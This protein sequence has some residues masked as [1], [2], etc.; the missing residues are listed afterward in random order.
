MTADVPLRV[1]IATH[2][3][4][5]SAAHGRRQRWPL[6]KLYNCRTRFASHLVVCSDPASTTPSSGSKQMCACAGNLEEAQAMRARFGIS[7][8][9]PTSASTRVPFSFAFPLPTAAAQAPSASPTASH[10]SADAASPASSMHGD[11]CDSQSQPAA[12]T[13]ATAPPEEAHGQEDDQGAALSAEPDGQ[14][15]PWARH[16]ADSDD[17]PV[18]GERPPQCAFF[19]PLTLC[20]IGQ[21]PSTAKLRRGQLYGCRR[22]ILDL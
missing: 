19:C 6:L 22:P 10:S 4:T 3:N 7:A 2:C 18:R 20:Q 8:A 17:Q 14:A 9:D 12:G 16:G 1:Q 15:W 5:L 21:T 13:D 11:H